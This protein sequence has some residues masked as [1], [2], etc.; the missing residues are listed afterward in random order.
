[1]T[2]SQDLEGRGANQWSRSAIEIDRRDRAF[3]PWPVAET[4]L[5]GAQL[6]VWAAAPE[7]ATM[8]AQPGAIVRTDGQGIHVVTGAGTLV[9]TRVQVAGRKAIAA[10][11]LARSQRLDGIVLGA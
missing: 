9:L 6:R 4:M 7:A 1:M 5:K 11:E 8:T 10:S 2:Y 3:N